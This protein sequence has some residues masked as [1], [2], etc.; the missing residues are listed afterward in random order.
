M[1][2]EAVKY[3]AHPDVPA[4]GNVQ[5]QIGLPCEEDARKK[6]HQT[7]YDKAEDG[8]GNGLWVQ[9]KRKDAAD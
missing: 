5:V 9:R 1:M 6:L 3:V 2:G 8:S 7:F 4:A